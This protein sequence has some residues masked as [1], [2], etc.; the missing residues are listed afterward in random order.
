MPPGTSEERHKHSRVRQFFFVLSGT[1]T[2]ELEDELKDIQYV[3]GVH[4]GLQV[5]PGQMHQARNEHQK[6][7]EFLV[8]SDGITREDRQET[9]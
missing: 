4:Q 6:D 3:L 8:I 5:P 9:L 1:L 7:A 2:L